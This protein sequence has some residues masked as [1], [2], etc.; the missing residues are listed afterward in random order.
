MHLFQRFI[1]PVAIASST[2]LSHAGCFSDCCNIHR[3]DHSD[4]L[5]EARVTALSTFLCEKTNIVHTSATLSIVDRL[6][7]HKAVPEELSICYQGGL[8]NGKKSFDSRSLKLEV[9]EQYFIYLVQGDN[10]EWSAYQAHAERKNKQKPRSQKKFY[11]RIATLH[12]ETQ[13]P[14]EEISYEAITEGVSKSTVTTYGFGEISGVPAR[15]TRGDSNQLIQVEVDSEFLPSGISQTQALAA[16][17]SAL[18]AWQDTS[19]LQFQITQ[20]YNFDTAASAMDG[21]D[22]ILHIQLHDTYDPIA[23]SSTLGVGGGSLYSSSG[24]TINGIAFA[25]AASRY[26]VLNDD[27]SSNEDLTKLEL[28]LTHEIGHALGLSHSS[29]TSNESDSDL[30]EA[31]MFYRL[32]NDGRGAALRPYDTNQMVIGY[33]TNTPPVGS[34]HFIRAVS[35]SAGQPTPLANTIQLN[36]FDADSDTLT[37]NL[38]SQSNSNGTFSF[39]TSSGVVSYTSAGRFSTGDLTSSNSNSSSSYYDLLTY[40]ISDGVHTSPT[41][42]VRIVGYTPDTNTSSELPSSW[43]TTHFG[44]STPSHTAD[45]DGDGVN[46]LLEFIRNTDPNDATDGAV[47]LTF[48]FK[49]NSLTLPT[50]LH[51]DRAVLESSSDL[52][53]W[54]TVT[55]VFQVDPS[56]PENA[57]LYIPS[58]DAE[59]KLFYR[60]SITR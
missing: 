29:E 24:G 12:Q 14:T 16:V 53:N 52:I 60:A 45:A 34:H 47:G 10:G 49:Q 20:N 42:S 4:A 2:M 39:D 7:Q 33:P 36:G 28:V 50:L 30:A 57:T 38:I 18:D 15:L 51:A 48:D 3:V 22:N 9:D 37:Y 43:V 46:N 19:S 31:T 1:L 40:S 6:T 55:T 23:D 17:R 11:N 5:V 32:Q 59:A 54:N 58:S 26:V 21:G 44:A 56:A 27:A 13:E 8:K 25:T 35:R 41:Y